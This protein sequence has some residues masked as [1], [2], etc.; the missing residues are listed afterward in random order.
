MI[1]NHKDMKKLKTLLIGKASGLVYKLSNRWNCWMRNILIIPSLRKRI[2]DGRVINQSFLCNNCTGAM[3]MHD[4]GKRFDSPT[5]NLWMT[6]K[7]FLYL[8]KNIRVLLNME[9][10]DVTPPEC[11]YP[12]GILGECTIHFLHYKNFKD[13]VLCWERRIKRLDIENMS[14]IL[15]D[16]GISTRELEAFDKLPI[17]NKIAFVRYEKTRINCAYK[18]D[19]PLNIKDFKITD[20]LGFWGRRYYDQLNFVDFFTKHEL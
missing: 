6:P 12:I 11:S 19:Y 9:I 10:I 7:D 8:V 20:Y 14:L 16:N 13:A 2:S 4:M 1:Q 15:I 18:I 17:K 5:V 3:M